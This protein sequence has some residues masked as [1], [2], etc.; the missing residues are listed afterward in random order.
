MVHLQ[1]SEHRLVNIRRRSLCDNCS[2]R[3]CTSFDGSR[4][5]EC[6]GFRPLFVV[7]MKCREC[8]AIYDPYGN[9][10]ALDYELCP[11]CNHY[12]S[13]GKPVMTLVCRE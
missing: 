11:E 8:G 7:L 2:E 13:D 3:R 10:C 9:I 4:V 12:V 6:R 5:T 1:V